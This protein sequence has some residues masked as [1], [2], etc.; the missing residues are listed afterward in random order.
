VK[1]L[2]VLQERRVRPVG[3]H[4]EAAVDVRVLAA[5]NR[6]VEEMVKAGTFRQDLYYRLN[7]IR[8]EVPPL[9]ERRADVREL[10]EHFLEG[11]SRELGKEV[12]SFAPDAL[13]AI[14]AH[15]FPGN[16]RELENV[17]ERAVALAS[18]SVIGLGDLPRE[19][20]GAAAQATPGLLA[21]PEEGCNLDDVVSELERRLIVQALERAGGVRTHAA[22]LLGLTLRTLRYRMQKLGLADEADGEPTSETIRIDDDPG[23]SSSK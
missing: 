18:S 7:V 3:A 4:A 13:R 9:R 1:L 11:F 19:I 8:I 17:V 6:N 12:T 16:V 10:A 23:S 15:D 2:R 5:T 14:D 20:V 22:K 21:L